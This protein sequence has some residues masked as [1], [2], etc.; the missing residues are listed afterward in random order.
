[1]GT[2]LTERIVD[3]SPISSIHDCIQRVSGT[4]PMWNNLKSVLRIVPVICALLEGC[5][6][7]AGLFKAFGLKTGNVEGRK[8]EL[9]LSVHCGVACITILL[10]YLNKLNYL[11]AKSASRGVCNADPYWRPQLRSISGVRA[12]G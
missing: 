7:P 3:V 2:S 12:S 6:H 9:D 4:N 11:L 5:F 8:V 10:D 1:M